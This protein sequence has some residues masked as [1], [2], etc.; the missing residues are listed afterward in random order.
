MS[1]FFSFVEYLQR[2]HSYMVEND[3]SKRESLLRVYID[4]SKSIRQKS[5]TWADGKSQNRF[6]YAKLSKLFP[7]LVF[8]CCFIHT[9]TTATLQNS[10]ETSLNEFVGVISQSI[11]RYSKLI[12]MSSI[13][14]IIIIFFIMHQQ[15]IVHAVATAYRNVVQSVFLSPSLPHTHNVVMLFVRFV[16]CCLSPSFQ[17]GHSAPTNFSW[18][19]WLIKQSDSN[20]AQKDNTSTTSNNNNN[21]NANYIHNI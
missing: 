16:E 20:R 9:H 8:H 15:I 4:E 1:V 12:D 17:T 14:I 19:Y 13:I 7:L 3:H 21:N 18:A 5:M 11:F 2:A 6:R 10:I